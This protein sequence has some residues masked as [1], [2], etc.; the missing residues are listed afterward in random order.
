MWLVVGLGNPGTQYADHRHNLGFRVV[1]ELARRAGSPAA[2]AKFGAELCDAKVAGERVLLCKPMEYMNLS[3]QAVV[4]TSAF[5][6]VPPAE[7]IVIHD[8]LDLPFGQLRLAPGGGAGGH[9]GIRSIIADWGTPDFLRVRVGVARP[10]AGHDPA[11]YLLSPF[12]RAEEAALPD[13]VAQAADATEAIVRS[14]LTTAMN[15]FNP[16]KKSQ[17][18]PPKP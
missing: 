12:S 10:P 3:G 15:R 8:E 7:T 6:K 17:E 11:N 14:G 5:W 16:R 4:R 2:R 13:I 9:N 1:D 18:N